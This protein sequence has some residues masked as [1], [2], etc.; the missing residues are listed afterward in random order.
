MSVNAEIIHCTPRGLPVYRGRDKGQQKPL[1]YPSKFLHQNQAEIEG[2]FQRL[3]TNMK[4]HKD[5]EIR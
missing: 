4:Q 2:K 1:D 5:L 3:V